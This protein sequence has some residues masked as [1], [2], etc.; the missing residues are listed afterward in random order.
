MLNEKL[1][2][3]L[4]AKKSI[5]QKF[6]DLHEK[7]KFLAEMSR[8]NSKAITKEFINNFSG[9]DEEVLFMLDYSNDCESMHKFRQDYLK[10]KQ[11]DSAGYY[12]SSA[13]IG[14]QVDMTNSD[15]ELKKSADSLKKMFHLI[16][17]VS[18]V[19]YNTK[20]K[21]FNIVQLGTCSLI[22]FEEFPSTV[23]LVEKGGL[24]QATTLERRHNEVFADWSEDLGQ[25]LIDAKVK[26]E[27]KYGY[28]TDDDE[29]F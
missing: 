16:K 11:L 22:N 28:K 20:D 29:E 3:L 26:L 2:S 10:S 25:V 18:D 6:A 17:P 23:Y 5:A 1:K 13:Q 27:N 8:A 19:N 9:S 15:E 14:L 7:Q 4:E 24:Y 21:K 12:P